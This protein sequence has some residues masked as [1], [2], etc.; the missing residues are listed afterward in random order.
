MHKAQIISPFSLSLTCPKEDGHPQT[1][2][3]N[4]YLR[5]N[6]KNTCTW[7]HD[8]LRLTYT[9][10]SHHQQIISIRQSH[11]KYALLLLSLPPNHHIVNPSPMQPPHCNIC[12][13]IATLF[14]TNKMVQPIM[15]GP[16]HTITMQL[17]IH[18]MVF[19][20]NPYAFPYYMVT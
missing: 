7:I 4:N 6:Q 9:T 3:E 19:K 11:S 17:F 12:L 1:S 15:I 16:V 14:R 10:T 8:M 18:H 2:Y 13:P 5:R 20:Q